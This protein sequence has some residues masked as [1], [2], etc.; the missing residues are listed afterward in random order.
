ML[1]IQ[2]EGLVIKR[3]DSCWTPNDKGG[4]WLKLKPQSEDIDALVIGTWPGT[5]AYGGAPGQ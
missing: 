4:A 2:E 1:L 3:P 5:R